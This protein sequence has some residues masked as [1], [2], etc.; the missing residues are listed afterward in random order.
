MINVENNLFL[1]FGEVRISY[2]R[3]Y[4]GVVDVP[5]LQDAGLD[6]EYFR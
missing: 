5:L 6:V 4:D 3:C 2:D 1:A